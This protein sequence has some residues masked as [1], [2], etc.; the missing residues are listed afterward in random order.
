MGALILPI[1]STVYVDA[2]IVIYAVEKI[3]PFASLLDPLW[4][5]S[6]RSEIAV[7]TSELTWMECLAGPIKMGDHILESTFRGFLTADDI[8]L[9]PIDIRVWDEAAHLR[10]LGLRTPDAVHA[11][12]ALSVSSTIFL[13]NDSVFCRV[14][15]LP[16]ALLSAL[17]SIV[18]EPAR[19]VPADR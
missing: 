14:P 3:E 16:V 12:A 5:A 8:R 1:P 4:V 17:D 11:A 19:E 10:S 7:V 2:N 9:T 6:Q 13:T 18:I 15:Q